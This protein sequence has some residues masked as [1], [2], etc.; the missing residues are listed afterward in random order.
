MQLGQNNH[1]AYNPG[2]SHKIRSDVL[3]EIIILSQAQGNHTKHADGL[4]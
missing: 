1:F 2:P 3:D 4:Q